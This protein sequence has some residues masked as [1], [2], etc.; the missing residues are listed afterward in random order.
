VII[1]VF[2][3]IA[4]FAILSEYGAFNVEVWE[5]ENPLK[6]PV[7]VT[8]V[9]NGTITLADGRSFRPAGV[10]RAHNVSIEDYDY[11]LGVIA[12]QG[13]VVARDLGDGRALMLAE[14]KFYNWCGTRGYNGN[15]WARWAGS[16]IQCP[17]SEVLVQSGYG[18]LDLDTPGLT[19]RERWRLKGIEH[20]CPI[21]E[22][23]TRISRDL[24]AFR[25][26]GIESCFDNYDEMLESVW[27]PPAP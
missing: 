13:V 27:K 1:A 21:A 8:N 23:P 4:A 7:A 15:P 20:V 6:N 25:Y 18:Q 26:G 10:Q 19:P 16:Y 22:S 2:G 17:I 3:A 5:R 14:P 12:A 11:A 24:S 9:S